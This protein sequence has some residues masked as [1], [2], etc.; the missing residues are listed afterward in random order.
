MHYTESIEA[1]TIQLYNVKMLVENANGMSLCHQP[2]L[3]Q[4]QHTL[5]LLLLKNMAA[6]RSV[7][8]CL[9]MCG[10]AADKAT[11]DL[12]YKACVLNLISTL[13]MAA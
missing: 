5:S 8:S 6:S 3:I 7:M 10:F 11:W 12:H 4:R 9:V 1:V 13:Y 2:K